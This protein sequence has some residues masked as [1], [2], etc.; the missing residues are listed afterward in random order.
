MLY[1][2]DKD[3]GESGINPITGQPFDSSWLLFTLT[4]TDR[5]QILCG[6]DKF[7]PYTIQMSR[8]FPHWKMAVGDFTGFYGDKNFNILVSM[9]DADWHEAIQYYGCHRYNDRYMRHNEPSVLVHST[10]YDNWL[11]I[12]ADG[13]LKSWHILQKEKAGWE[14]CPIGRQLGDPEDF[15]NYVMFADGA[16]SGEIVVLSKQHG[17]I[18]MDGDMPYTPG[19][20][21]YFDMRKIAADGLLV[22]DGLHLKVENRLPLSPYLLWY[23]TWDRIGL[24]D[25]RSTPKE[26]TEKSNALF[27]RL[28]QGSVG[29][30][31]D[32][33]Q[34]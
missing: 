34:L 28:F 31:M 27:N 11:S 7:G 14:D 5:Y 15:S 25:N 24:S 6:K 17:K 1:R 4:E 30:S 22:R 21:L 12:Q 26:F 13:C 29:T 32:K 3:V 16:I 2:L 8:H 10:T 9:P 23:A 18:L 20:R 19:V 33:Q